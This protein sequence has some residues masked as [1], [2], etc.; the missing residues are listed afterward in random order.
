MRNI[1][2]TLWIL[3]VFLISVSMPSAQQPP[4]Q[5]QAIDGDGTLR[6]IQ[7][8]ILM[9]HYV[10]MLPPDADAI[11]RGLTLHPD[12]FRQHI[13]YLAENN[14]NTISLYDL[15]NA[16][17]NGA[18]LPPNPVILTFDDGY[19]DAYTTVFPILQAND[20]TATFFIISQFADDNL[21]GYMTW[22]QINEMATAGMSMEGHTKTH[23]ALIERDFE[24]LVFQV[25]GSLESLAVHS[26]QIP[27]MF[28]Y[29]IGRY[30]DNTLQ[31][32]ASTPVER[33]VTTQVGTL[34]TTDNRFELDRMRIT[35]ETGVAG[36]AYLL[37]YR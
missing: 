17:E 16:L 12:I 3:I 32:M 33:A 26:G 15:D 14:Y 27:R 30:D 34:H 20:M 1:K 13:A 9:Y 28:A 5:W 23:P 18:T 36:L 37:T 22:E 6:R 8:P 29:P 35:D 11:R 2:S 21:A 31:F 24:F 19:S 4:N 10:S 25:M 7:V